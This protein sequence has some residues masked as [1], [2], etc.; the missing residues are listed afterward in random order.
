MVFV[1]EDK[2]NFK[3]ISAASYLASFLHKTLFI[4]RSFIYL[5]LTVFQ[6]KL[7]M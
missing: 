3:K 1:C 5:N 6:K 2:K 7:N 4:L